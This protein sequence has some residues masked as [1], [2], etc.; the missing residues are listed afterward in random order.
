VRGAGGGGGVGGW[1]GGGVVCV[2]WYEVGGRLKWGRC[3]SGQS[4]GQSGA[5]G[6]G[7]R[8]WGGAR[9]ETERGAELRG[10]GVCCRGATSKE[11]VKS[12]VRIHKSINQL[13]CL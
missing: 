5:C 9:G 10:G 3:L 8:G 2:I 13:P 6:G 7:A 12:E 1:G 11:N 4:G